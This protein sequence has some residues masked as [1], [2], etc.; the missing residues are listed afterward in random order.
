MKASFSLCLSI[1]PGWNF[2][3][4]QCL[5]WRT[6][7]AIRVRGRGNSASP[8]PELFVYRTG[9]VSTQS[10]PVSWLDNSGK[11]QPL[12][13]TPGI[14]VAPRFSPDGQRLALMHIA[15]GDR[16]VVVYDWQRDTMSRLAFEPNKHRV[17]HMEPRRQAHRV[18]VLLRRR[19]QDRLDPR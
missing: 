12:I 15:G 6:W 10:W 1:P 18:S 14:Y 3:A 19:F 5:S 17:S 16:H 13:A 9:K 4:R 2:S 7:R 8:G 11:T